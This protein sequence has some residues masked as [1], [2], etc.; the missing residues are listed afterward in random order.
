MMM[1]IKYNTFIPIFLVVACFFNNASAQ[2]KIQEL[3]NIEK[4]D[5]S[6]SVRLTGQ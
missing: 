6:Y 3:E 2:T 5:A 1:N 4:A